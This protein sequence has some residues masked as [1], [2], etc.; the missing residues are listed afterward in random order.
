MCLLQDCFAYSTSQE[1]FILPGLFNGCCT[2]R[3]ATRE[4]AVGSS[5]WTVDWRNCRL[6][7]ATPAF[8][9]IRSLNVGCGEGGRLKTED[10]NQIGYFTPVRDS[11]TSHSLADRSA[12]NILPASSVSAGCPLWLPKPSGPIYSPPRSSRCVA[13]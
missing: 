13:A 10:W 12:L 1:N 4:Q 6:P 2:K 5:K 7:L 11:E 8:F 9:N 3:H